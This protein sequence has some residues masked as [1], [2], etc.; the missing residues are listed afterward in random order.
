MTVTRQDAWTPDDD[1]LL[2]EV[3]LRHIREGSTQLCAFEEVG[4]RLSRTAAAC[5]FRWNSAVRK[6][7]EDA[8][9]IAKAHRQERK[10]AKRRLKS[11]SPVPLMEKASL[12]EETSHA[13]VDE[14]IAVRQQEM[15]EE[16]SLDV[17]IRFLRG[18]KDAYKRMKQ[19]E[20]EAADSRKEL[21]ELRTENESLRE[22]LSL[23]KSD[24]QVVNDD[25]KA[26]IQIMDR[27]RKM[28]FLGGEEEVD[29][30]PR[31][32]MDANGNLERVDYR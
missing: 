30:K 3:T 1:L 14:A 12:A 11:I 29:V 24:Y 23:M 25:Y 15:Q 27:A 10:K 20:K 16:I 19:L 31:F 26:L 2:A 32:K 21:E 8:I 9:Q 4:E 17:V 5:G 7:Y 18:Q 13:E 28:A 6:R 22:E